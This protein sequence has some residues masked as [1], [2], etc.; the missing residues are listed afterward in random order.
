MKAKKRVTKLVLAVILVFTSKSNYSEI[1]KW[2]IKFYP[3]CWTPIQLV[4]VHKATGSTDWDVDYKKL[5]LQV[6]FSI[7]CTKVDPGNHQDRS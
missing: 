1:L 7:I 4:L 5:L 6:G 3:V 2:N